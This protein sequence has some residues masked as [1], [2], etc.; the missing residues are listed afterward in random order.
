MPRRNLLGHRS[1]V[2]PPIDQSD[3]APSAWRTLH[4]IQPQAVA[5]LQFPQDI[6]ES[7]GA[8][9]LQEA[10]V[11]LDV[12]W[13]RVGGTD[14]LHQDDAPGR[15]A[16][17]LRQRGRNIFHAIEGVASENDVGLQLRRIL[18]AAGPE[19]GRLAGS[20]L[21][22]AAQKLR[23]HGQRGLD[24]KD[25]ANMVGDPPGERTGS[26]PDLKHSVAGAAAVAG[27]Q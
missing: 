4:R 17:H 11:E 1:T 22:P 8:L 2:G 20:C 9:A 27:G 14:A 23:P 25:L 7:M 10:P 13:R 26:G 24:R 12:Q 5:N 21:L 18:P 3:I 6:G 19:P 16:V 15:K